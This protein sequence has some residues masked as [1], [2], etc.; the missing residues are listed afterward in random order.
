VVDK[1]PLVITVRRST[2]VRVGIAALVLLALGIGIAVGFVVGSNSSPTTKSTDGGTS[3]TT[4]HGGTSSTPPS[5]TTT[6]TTV[7]PVPAVLS[8]GPASTPHVRP[9]KLTVGCAT[10]AVTVTAINWT[11]WRAATGGQGKGTLNVNN[12]QPNCAT[13][14]STSTPA[15][16]VVFNVVNGVFQDVSITPSKDVPKTPETT[17]TTIATS[18]STT[19]GPAPVAASQPGSGWGG[20]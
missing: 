12:C 16:V 14:T 3:T 5:A 9:A 4:A 13:G 18:T 1:D 8:C 17:S 19:S 10:G 15:I 11:L 7:A 20:E 2:Y 6:T